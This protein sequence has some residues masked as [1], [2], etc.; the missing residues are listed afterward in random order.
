MVIL[1]IEKFHDIVTIFEKQKTSLDLIKRNAQT[2]LSEP[3][4]KK[5]VPIFCKKI[6]LDL[7]ILSFSFN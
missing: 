3:S 4:S 1:T 6:H 7:N 2:F 5:L